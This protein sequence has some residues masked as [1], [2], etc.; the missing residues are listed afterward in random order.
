LRN[1]TTHTT[2]QLHAF[3]AYRFHFNG[4]ET[5]NEV[6]G[7][8]NVYD[9]GFRI[10]NPRLGKFLSVDPLTSSYPWLTPYQF[11]SNDPIRNIDIDGLEGGSAIEYV[12]TMIGRAIEDWWNSWSLPSLTPNKP[13]P[14]IKEEQKK[15]VIKKSNENQIKNQ[16]TNT[17]NITRKAKSNTAEKIKQTG[18]VEF[19][20]E[21]QSGIKDNANAQA[22]INDAANGDKMST[23]EYAHPKGAKVALNDNAANAFLSLAEK[24]KMSVSE[25]AGG[26]HGENSLHYQGKAYD[27]THVNG[28]Y[29]NKE[30]DISKEFVDAARA[31]GF[32]V[33]IEYEKNHIHLQWGSNN[34][35]KN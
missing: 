1:A 32:T 2:N 8:G 22:N 10:Y 21:H 16:T 20:T 33:N 19:A 3:S 26:K 11:S 15:P 28:N 24:Y 30:S 31:V 9:Y 18:N 25:I 23:S 14:P 35:P 6:Y 34:K 7:E 27:V 5:D 29:M 13:A 4:K 12:F 17:T